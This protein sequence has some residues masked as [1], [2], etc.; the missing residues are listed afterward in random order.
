MVISVVRR[1]GTRINTYNTPMHIH[2]HSLSK[3]GVGTRALGPLKLDIAY[4]VSQR[5]RCTYVFQGVTY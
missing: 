4:G 3:P 2:V 5:S 1:G